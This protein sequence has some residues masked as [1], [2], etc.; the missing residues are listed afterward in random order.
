MWS[1]EFYKTESGEE[2]VRSFL[3]GIETKLRAKAVRDIELLQRYGNGLREPFSK[4]IQDGVFELRTKQSTNI[5]RIMYFFYVN[6]KIVLTNGFIK[7]TQK[8]PPSEVEKALRY[9]KDFEGRQ[10]K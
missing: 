7:K 8:T 2:P 9:K 3:D 10:P 6:N 4:H 1:V 5:I